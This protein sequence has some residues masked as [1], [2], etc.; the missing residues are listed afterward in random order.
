MTFYKETVS[1]SKR[2][3]RNRQNAW[4][5]FDRIERVYYTDATMQTK[6]PNSKPKFYAKCKFCDHPNFGD[7]FVTMCNHIQ[8]CMGGSGPAVAARQKSAKERKEEYMARRDAKKKAADRATQAAA[9]QSMGLPQL[10][11]SGGDQLEPLSDITNGRRRKRRLSAMD[12]SSE[13]E[14]PLIIDSEKDINNL[15]E[16]ICQFRYA[17]NPNEALPTDYTTNLPPSVQV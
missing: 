10:N 6:L 2:L 11:Q 15:F 3:G 9:Q 12:I 1:P 17:E 13:I 16:D 8:H 5:W 7:D 14:R 4:D